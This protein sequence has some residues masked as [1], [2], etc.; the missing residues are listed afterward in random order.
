MLRSITHDHLAGLVVKAIVFKKFLG[1]RLAKLWN[2]GA[3]G[4][5]RATLLESGD[6][7]RLDVLRRI[8]VRL[9]RSE[10]KDFDAL[11]LHG[12]GF[13]VD[14]QCEGGGQ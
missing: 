9:T 7:G 5:F 13:A 3:W 11:S 12:F 10:T 1:N 4:V 6:S 2:T 8:H 14:S